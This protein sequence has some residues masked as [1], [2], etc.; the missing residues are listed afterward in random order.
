MNDEVLLESRTMR[1]RLVERTEVLDKV[2]ALA[3]L[4]DDLHATV[5]Q[6]ASYYEVDVKV[7]RKAI[8]NHREE[9]IEDGLK[10][11]QGEELTRFASEIT[12]L[13]RDGIIS[14]K[15]RF[16]T[17]IL[18]RAILRIG[19]LL[20]DSEI[21]KRVRTYLLNVEEVARREAPQVVVRAVQS[22]TWRKIAADVKA[23]QKLFEMVGLSK[24]AALA[25]AMDHEELETGIDLTPF[26]RLIRDSD[27]DKTINPTEIGRRLQP[28]QSAVMV[29]RLLERI[30]FQVRTVNKEWEPTEEGK[31]HADVMLTVVRH[32]DR[33][34]ADQIVETQKKAI[35]WKESVVDIL[36][37]ALSEEVEAK[38]K[39]SKMESSPSARQDV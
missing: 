16:L 33:H 7:I 19:M 31:P 38:K 6:A 18:R 24:P 23:K 5:E 15:T 22:L 20:R 2:K 25:Y 35:R 37:K 27:V 26:K 4:P 12:S 11:L 14:P 21:A 39:G 32:P 13:S 8:E 36:Q 3:L 34:H 28:P 17:L 29:N 30:G 1:N 10:V 9:L